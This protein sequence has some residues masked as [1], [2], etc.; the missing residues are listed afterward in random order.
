MNEIIS[1]TYKQKILNYFKSYKLHN[2][3]GL[4]GL[5][6]FT[7]TIAF[8]IRNFVTYASGPS[9]KIFF[10]IFDRFTWQSNVLLFVYMFLYFI[11]PK[12]SIFKNNRFL[13]MTMVWIFFT[14]FGY[15]VVLVGI[16]KDR[17]YSGSAIQVVINAWV[18]AIAPIWFI[19]YGIC[20][21]LSNPNKEPTFWKTLGYGMIYPVIYAI[22]LITIPYTFSDYR[23]N[24][25]IYD[26]VSGLA[27]S[28]YGKATNTYESSIAYAYILS[29]LIVFIPGS[30]ALFYYSWKGINLLY[31]KGIFKFNQPLHKSFI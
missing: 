1:Y 9:W 6:I 28:V 24:P 20:F 12:H 29:M 14:F 18:H 7:I 13:I 30:F 31:K 11:K 27:Y 21:M 22:Y 5:L 4:I 8:L 15:N 19:I 3:I 16:S 2:Y 23:L 10:G 17:G 26:N 25:E